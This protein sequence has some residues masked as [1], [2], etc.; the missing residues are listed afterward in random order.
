VIS[1]ERLE[2]IVINAIKDGKNANQVAA[3]TGV[4]LARVQ[5]MFH[6]VNGR[7]PVE[8]NLETRAKS[9]RETGYRSRG[10]G[11]RRERPQ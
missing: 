10:A 8:A 1:Q 3:G 7:D 5:L 11:H 2:A 4:P 9:R 6:R